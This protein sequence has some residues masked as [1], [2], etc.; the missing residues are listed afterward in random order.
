[1]LML[2][3]SENIEIAME[4]AKASLEVEGI[5]ISSTHTE[6]VRKVLSGEITDEEFEIESLKLVRQNI[7]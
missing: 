4:K 5:K 1:M 3:D 6:L 7:E 2:Q